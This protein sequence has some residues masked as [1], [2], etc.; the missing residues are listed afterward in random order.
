MK[1]KRIV[2]VGECL[3]LSAKFKL[4]YHI[5]IDDQDSIMIR[6]AENEGGGYFSDEWVKLDTILTKLES[7]KKPL[8][9]FSLHGIFEGKS[10]NTP[11][12]IFAVL[13]VEGLVERDLDN[14][15]VYVSC[16]PKPVIEVIEALIKAGTD[17]KVSNIHDGAKTSSSKS[18][19]TKKQN[20]NKS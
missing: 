9:S 17:I 11:G 7:A 12:F 4:I 1:T 8:T 16:D 13:Y 20:S 14:P 5:G 18:A 19:P 15:R 3:N 6:V 10:A 2:K